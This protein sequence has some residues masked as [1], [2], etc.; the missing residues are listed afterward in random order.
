MP[1]SM[2]TQRPL[3][4]GYRAVAEAPSASEYVRMR[5]IAGLSPRTE[6]QAHGALENSWRWITIRDQTTGT[7]AAMGRVIGDGTW[8]FHIADIATHPERQ[9]QGL[10]RYVMVELL[11]EILIHAEP[12]PY[13]TLIGDP[14][15]HALYRSLG[16]HDVSPSLGMAYTPGGRTAD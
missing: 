5:S 9:R 6:A 11:R 1:D 10:G 15:G 14:P 8:Y 2:P 12:H 13:I 7:L 4:E 3:P 16:F